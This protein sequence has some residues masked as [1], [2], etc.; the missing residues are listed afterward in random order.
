MDSNSYIKTKLGLAEELWLCTVHTKLECLRS[1]RRC[2]ESYTRG[3][4]SWMA[5]TEDIMHMERCRWQ[6]TV[7]SFDGALRTAAFAQEGELQRYVADP[8]EFVKMR[9]DTGLVFSAE[10]AVET[11]TMERTATVVNG[12]RSSGLFQH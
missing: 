1:S 8:A 4:I 3:L 11:S 6:M 7:Q 5:D 12:A 9:K 10:V 2:R